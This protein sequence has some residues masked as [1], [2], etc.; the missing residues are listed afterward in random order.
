[1]RGKDSGAAVPRCLP[2]PA[3]ALPPYL[4]SAPASRPLGRGSA[5]GGGDKAWT[6]LRRADGRAPRPASLLAPRATTGGARAS[7]G[8]GLLGEG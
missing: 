6:E 4:P 2:L 3:V 7:E 8:A 1:M 5:G